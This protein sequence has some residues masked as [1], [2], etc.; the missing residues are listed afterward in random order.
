MRRITRP[1]QLRIKMQS[2]AYPHNLKRLLTLM[3]FET[4]YDVHSSST[5]SRASL[6]IAP[7]GETALLV[8]KPQKQTQSRYTIVS[9]SLAYPI[10][11]SVTC[12]LATSTSF[13]S[14]KPSK[15]GKY[16]RPSLTSQPLSFANS[17]T[18]PSDSRNSRF[19]AFA[20]GKLGYAFSE[21]DAISARIVP[22]RTYTSPR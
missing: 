4:R 18:L 1:G 20:I 8:Q 21:Q 15:S 12:L 22:T 14:L 10:V 16:I 7:S 3:M 9:N 6:A 11:F 13:S 2:P 19:F 5:A 17:T